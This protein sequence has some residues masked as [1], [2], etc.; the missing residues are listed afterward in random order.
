ML[1]VPEVG[2]AVELTVF[3]S[4]V[5]ICEIRNSVIF[6]IPFW[7]IELFFSLMRLF[8]MS[9]PPVAFHSLFCLQNPYVWR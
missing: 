8:D 5:E 2:E 6:V 4:H 3:V 1:H 9:W 7:M